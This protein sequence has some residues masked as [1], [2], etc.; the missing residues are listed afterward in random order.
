M[1]KMRGLLLRFAG[2][3]GIRRGDTEL[4]EELELHLA[5]HVEDN[6]RSGMSPEEARRQALIKLG[7]MARTKEIYRDRNRLPLLETLLQDLRYGAR[8]LRKNPGFST[9]AVVTLAL[10]IGANTAVFSVVRA[11]LLKSLPYPDP[12]RLVAL[13]EYQVH[14]GGQSV[15]WMDFREWQAQTTAFE[16]IA[17]Y[18]PHHFVLTGLDKPDMLRAG[19]VTSGFFP[20]LGTQ[21][22]LGRTFVPD[23][24]RAGAARTTV[25]SY[26][27]WRTR[28][29]GDPAALGRTLRL[30]DT[31]YTIIGVLPPN[32]KF[33]PVRIDLYVPAGLESA[34]LAWI[35]RGNHE[36]LAALA[37]LR[38]GVSL[39]AAR[40]DVDTIMQRLE[41][42]Y[43]ESNDGQRARV[44]PFYAETV[45]D[46]QRPLFILLGAAI[47]VLLIAC[48]NVAN[49]ALARAAGRARE[50]AVRVAIGARRGRIVRQLLTESLLLSFLGGLI[51]FVFARWAIRPLLFMAPRGIPRLDETQMDASVFVF[52]FVTAA[53]AGIAFGLAPA[54]QNSPTRLA[55]S[56]GEAGR[57]TSTSRQGQ[58]LRASL[59]I[60]EISLVSVLVIASGLLIRSLIGA[61]AVNAGFR[62]DHLLALDVNLPTTTRYKTDAQQTLFLT[63][64]L[65]RL[66]SLPGV[67]SASAAFCPPLV[68][69]CWDSVFLISGRP[70]PPVSQEPR[71]AFNIAE[72]GYF[73]TMEVPLLAGRNFATTDTYDSPKVILINET[74]AKRW[75]P[76]ESPLGKRIR[77]GSIKAPELEII[78]IVGDLKEDG[79]DQPQWPEV[80]EAAA[81]NTLPSMTLV[82]R[83]AGEPMALAASAEDAIHQVDKDQPL[84]HVQ[85]MS[86]Y[87][88]VSLAQR[89]FETLLLGIFST[90]ALVLAAVG[91]YGLVGYMV[92]QRTYEIGIRMAL[93]A[94]KRSVLALVLRFGLRLVTYG[95][96]AGLVVSLVVTRLVQSLLFGIG[97][98][99]PL[100]F[101]S[102]TIVLAIVALAACYFPARRATQV[103]PL[104]ALRCE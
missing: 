87:L 15:S 49:L 21:T 94:Q 16:S 74:M 13:S 59:L 92:A 28:L 19:E 47:C 38:P 33:F 100:T 67:Q 68:G 20:L 39:A 50:F 96:A 25:L 45:G 88:Q 32:F 101:I 44:T 78:G 62:V 64:A 31:A 58:R 54:L 23:D 22:V 42:Q 69:T 80:F 63:E 93:G 66:R 53:L 40:T 61:L 6:I 2:L 90:L 18:R 97:E 72:P 29:G 41:Q 75:W 103:D 12:E 14:N 98:R 71:A 37:R 81:Q 76:H 89:K 55:A 43:P 77:Q 30:D 46:V 91:I 26:S 36:G 9:I 27:F 86:A 56:L 102:V 95:V 4:T 17:V 84:S 35:T 1:R 104:V 60:A 57:R 48:A 10:G 73:H 34:Y 65:G 8:M 3:L 83:T 51:G 82:V 7:G 85:P 99:D 52:T 11:V 70:V 79:V 5:M 24:D